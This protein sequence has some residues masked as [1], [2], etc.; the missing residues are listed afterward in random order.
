MGVY[1]P[2]SMESRTLKGD[3]L[4]A[5]EVQGRSGALALMS[6]RTE[7]SWLGAG[8]FF[9]SSDPVKK[10]LSG[11]F[12]R[13]IRDGHLAVNPVKT[14][15]KFR[16]NNELVT[17]LTA[18]EE[19]AVRSALPS[20]TWRNL[21]WTN[22]HGMATG[23][24]LCPGL[25]WPEWTNRGSREVGGLEDTGKNGAAL[26]S[27]CPDHLHAAVERLVSPPEGAVEL[28]RN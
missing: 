10:V 16:E 6:A 1:E 9:K 25:P 19:E 20:V 7:N 13:A 23:T 15:N 21:T 12:K 26:R 4:A 14:V 27:P 18:K 28:A 5:A 2:S 3:P 8:E 17:Y 11:M 24:P 22:T